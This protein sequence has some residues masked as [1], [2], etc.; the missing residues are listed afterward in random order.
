MRSELARFPYISE[1]ARHLLTDNVG[2]ALHMSGRLGANGTEI[3]AVARTAFVNS[4]STSLWVAV[5]LAVSATI[6]ALV[7][8]PRHERQD[9]AVAT[10]GPAP[11][12]PTLQELPSSASSGP[13]STLDPVAA[14]AV[15]QG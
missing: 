3:A 15:I 1:P 5:G 9:H 2:S 6:I 12:V 8:L 4:M 7:Y 10:H 13:S 14:T 11:M